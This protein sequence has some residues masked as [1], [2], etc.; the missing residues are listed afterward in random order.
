MSTFDLKL[1]TTVKGGHVVWPENQSRR[2]VKFIFREER[3]KRE[4]IFYL[5]RFNLINYEEVPFLFVAL[6]LAERNSSL[7][8]RATITTTTR[9]CFHASSQILSLSLL[10]KKKERER[11][12][13]D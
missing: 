7:A 13:E 9:V 3:Q 5:S 2:G 8:S 6:F 10:F 4:H 12:R 11:E 1:E